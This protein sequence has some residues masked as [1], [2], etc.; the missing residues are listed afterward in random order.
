MRWFDNGI[1]HGMDV[2]TNTRQHRDI[3]PVPHQAYCSFIIKEN[4]KPGQFLD[5][6]VPVCVFFLKLLYE[7]WSQQ[8][9][10][11]YFIKSIYNDVNL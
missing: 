11:S 7:F 4:E 5:Y 9:L 3:Y 8:T 6:P 1:R 2:D 10:I